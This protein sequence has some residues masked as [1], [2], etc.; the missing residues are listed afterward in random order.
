MQNDLVECSDVAEPS[1]K[2]PR[3]N[4]TDPPKPTVGADDVVRDETY[5]FDDGSCV[6]KVESTLFNVSGSLTSQ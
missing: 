3:L 4:D 2:R 1:R 6:L 5:Y